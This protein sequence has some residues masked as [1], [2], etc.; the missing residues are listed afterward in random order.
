MSTFCFV[1]SRR[2]VF[3]ASPVHGKKPAK[4]MCLERLR[5]VYLVVPR[6]VNF[7]VLNLSVH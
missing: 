4:G 7:S 6:V 1:A 3:L 2:Q 5:D